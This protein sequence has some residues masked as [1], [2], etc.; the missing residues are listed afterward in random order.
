[1]SVGWRSVLYAAAP[2]L[3]PHLVGADAAATMTVM[4]RALAL[5]LPV[6]ALHALVLAATRG[7]GSMRPTVVVENIGRLGLQA[8]A[9]LVV[10][11]AGGGALAL[12]LAWSLPYVLGLVVAGVWLRRPGRAHDDGDEVP[13]TPLGHAGP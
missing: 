5:V 6:A 1:M 7:T 8:V 13:P 3:A 11:L 2:A 4:L 12:A 9:V 10:Y